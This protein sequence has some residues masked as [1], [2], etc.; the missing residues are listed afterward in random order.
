MKQLNEIS[1]IE[2]EKEFNKFLNFIKRRKNSKNSENY[3]T[4]KQFI[5][6]LDLK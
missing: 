4:L 1:F 6:L 5:Q 3:L 2:N